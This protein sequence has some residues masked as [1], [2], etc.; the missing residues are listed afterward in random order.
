M[1][2]EEKSE[3]KSAIKS[4]EED[5]PDKDYEMLMIQWKIQTVLA[6]TTLDNEQKQKII[7]EHKAMLEK[8]TPDE[9]SQKLLYD[10]IQEDIQTALNSL[11]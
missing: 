5:A 7:L 2:S 4:V 11:K 8:L 10:K 9:E 6:K 3:N 1:R